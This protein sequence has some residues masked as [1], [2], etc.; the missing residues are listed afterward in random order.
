MT[1]SILMSKEP[2]RDLHGLVQGHEKGLEIVL[3][4]FL[5]E[6]D[7]HF[8]A[9]DL[10]YNDPEGVAASTDFLDSLC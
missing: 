2:P 8:L 3:A 4:Q 7:V 1:L 6:H 9:H 10:V 5:F